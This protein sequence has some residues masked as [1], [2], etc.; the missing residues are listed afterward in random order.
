MRRTERAVRRAWWPAALLLT[1][2]CAAACGP[3]PG[4]DG[5][6]GPRPT[7]RPAVAGATGD[8]IGALFLGAV[9]GPRM[10]TASVVASPRHN[11]LVTAAH[12]VQTA[13]RG[14]FDDLVFAPGY[15][16]GRTPYG[17]WPVT[18]ITV[19]P[20]WSL[21]EDPEYDVAFLTVAEVQ[22]QRIEDRVG[23]NPLGTG[24]GVGLPVSVTGYPNDSGTPVTCSGRTGAQGP[25]QERFECSGYTVGTSGSPW[26]TEDGKVVGVIGGYQQGGNTDATSYSIAFDRRVTELYRLATG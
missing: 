26:L 4:P 9:T 10:C 3:D 6:T 16:D 19:D 17:V 7:A 14:R 8:R 12:C 13:E 21:G 1:I 23:A 11:L 5:R 18:S 20:R 22:G 25:T 2:H 15:R 24:L